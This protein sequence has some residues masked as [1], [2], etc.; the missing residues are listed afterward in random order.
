MKL[1]LKHMWPALVMILF[2][3]A[4]EY[5]LSWLPMPFKVDDSGN[6]LVTIGDVAYHGV[7][8]LGYA[9]LLA[10]IILYTKEEHKGARLAYIG[11]ILWNIKEVLDR[12][13]YVAESQFDFIS[14]NLFFSISENDIGFMFQVFNII[15]VTIFGIIAC[16]QCTLFFRFLALFSWPYWLRSA[17]T[18]KKCPK[19]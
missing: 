16:T 15:L 18:K 4:N 10:S 5:I 19:S 17:C 6:V 11:L 1:F 14:K 3:I 9:S 8:K 13:Y 12:I 7:M 2:A